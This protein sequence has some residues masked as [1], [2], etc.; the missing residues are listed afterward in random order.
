MAGA[1][2]LVTLLSGL[3]YL[4]Y[5]ALDRLYP[6]ELWRYFR[7]LPAAGSGS[8][9]YRDLD[10]QLLVVSP[11]DP[12]RARR[13]TAMTAPAAGS[14]SGGAPG[15]AATQEIVR[16]AVVLPGG[17]AVAYFATEKRAGRPDADHLKV[18]A[19][20]GRLIQDLPV[21]EAAGEPILSSIYVS[22]SGRY[23]AVTSRDRTHVYYFD[24]TS[25]GALTPG[26]AD[27][28]PEPMLWY[29]NGD[30]RTAP[31]PNQVAYAVS[32]DGKRRAQVQEG[33]RRAPDCGDG[34]RCELAREL[35]VSPVTVTGVT[36]SGLSLYSAFSS[37][38]AEGWGPIPSQPAARFYGRLVWSPDGTQLLF[39]TQDEATSRVY[40]ISADG[41]T[42]PRL[43]LDGAEALDWTP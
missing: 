40:V 38:A 34:P 27:A 5:G 7:P 24:V 10:G 30:L 41:K 19:L 39:T 6:Q 18:V 37:F 22:A 13:L 20:D 33:T 26:Q 2:L 42:R 35:S 4:T 28:P 32:P 3:G 15:G 16:D 9:F 23:V 25:G 14:A 11:N 36:R 21:V 31:F 43:L 29:R 1:V 17:Q 8:I 12:S